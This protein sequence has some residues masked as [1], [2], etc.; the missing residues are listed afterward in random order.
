M[1][2]PLSLLYASGFLIK[3]TIKNPLKDVKNRQKLAKNP[4]NV[5][6]RRAA[7]PYQPMPIPTA[8]VIPTN[9]VNYPCFASGNSLV[10]KKLRINQKCDLTPSI[11]PSNA[12]V[13]TSANPPPNY[14]LSN[15][16]DHA[17]DAP[18]VME[19]RATIAAKAK[20]D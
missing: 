3:K 11:C 1:G 8:S 15:Q 17:K 16:H 13:A 10:V 9:L 19:G 5:F 7:K 4:F 2:L 12:G 6:E 20:R 14:S 18:R